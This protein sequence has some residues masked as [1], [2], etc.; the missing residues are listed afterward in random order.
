MQER[1]LNVALLV[2]TACA[3]VV[4]GL[5]VRREVVDPPA[6]AHAA[7]PVEVVSWREYGREGHRMGPPTARVTVVVFSDF[8]CPYCGALMRSLHEVRAAFPDEVAVVYRHYPLPNHPHALGAARASDCAATQGRFIEY[9]DALFAAQDSIGLVEWSRFAVS[10]G[11]QDL[12]A[13]QA[14]AAD[15]A[16]SARIVRDVSAGGR[17]RVTGTPTLLINGLRFQG[18]MPAET[19]AAHVRRALRDLARD[20][21]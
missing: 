17:L 16:R 5:V 20:A 9:H 1:A 6:R 8:Q 7:R 11:I 18:A 14:C 15:T 4:T 21:A 19:L 10:A 12:E 3:L 2:L 13:F